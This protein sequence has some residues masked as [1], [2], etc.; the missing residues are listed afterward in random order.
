MAAETNADAPKLA[1]VVKWYSTEKGYGFIAFEDRDIF[2]HINDISPRNA[3]IPGTPVK[4]K[5][6]RSRNG[7]PAAVKIEVVK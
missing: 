6:G 1:G 4:F 2:M 7:K 5:M 3:P